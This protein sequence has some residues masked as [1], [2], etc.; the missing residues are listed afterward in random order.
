MT[1]PTDRF[2]HIELGREVNRENKLLFEEK[3]VL[4]KTLSDD[5]LA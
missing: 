5:Q 1:I 2:G 4:Q 3:G